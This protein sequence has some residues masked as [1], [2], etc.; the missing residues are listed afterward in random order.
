M[1]AAARGETFPV[2]TARPLPDWAIALIVIGAALI[3]LTIIGL[4]IRFLI[5]DSIRKGV[6]SSRSSSFSGN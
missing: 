2:A 3:A 1:I 4:I 6:T 5:I